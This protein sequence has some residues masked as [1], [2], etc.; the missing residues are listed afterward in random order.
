MTGPVYECEVQD[1]FLLWPLR[2]RGN[3]LIFKRML[4]FTC[5]F[6]SRNF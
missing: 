6:V 3:Q 1:I 5:T 2:S 4:S